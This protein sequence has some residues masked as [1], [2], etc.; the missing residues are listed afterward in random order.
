MNK[1]AYNTLRMHPM[2]Y[3]S[4]Q[5]Q[6]INKGNAPVQLRLDTTQYSRDTVHDTLRGWGSDREG[7]GGIDGAQRGDITPIKNLIFK[8]V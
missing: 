3:A 5:I 7:G 1:T 8:E 4:M 2:L 6:Y